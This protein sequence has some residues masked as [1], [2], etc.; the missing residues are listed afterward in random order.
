MYSKLKD[1]LIKKTAASER[2][3]LPLLFTSEELGDRKPTQ[4]LQHMQLLLGNS[5]APNQT[6]LSSGNYFFNSSPAMLA[7]CWPSLGIVSPDTLADMADKILEVAPPTVSSLTSP[8]VPSTPS[9]PPLPTSSEVGSGQRSVSYASLSPHCSS[10]LV[11]PAAHTP[12][13]VLTPAP[14]PPPLVHPPA[15]I[16]DRTSHLRFLVDTG[17]EV[18][19]TPPSCCGSSYPSTGPFLPAANQSPIA[20]H[21]VRPLCLNLGPRRPL[22]H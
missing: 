1:L 20:S 5:A 19:V 21:G 7:W 15:F 17:A 2:K 9:P 13:P 22:M 12:S 4:L 18:R 6:T 3:C 11:V 8:A 14:M 10:P 16:T